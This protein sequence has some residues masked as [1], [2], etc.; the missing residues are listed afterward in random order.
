M[1][2]SPNSVVALTYELHTTNEEGQQVFVEKADEQNPLVFL[3][4]VGM[5][6]PKFE[7]HLTGLKTGDEYAF[8]LS[9]ADGYG[10]I[11]PGAFADLPKTMFTEAGGELPNVGDVI[12]LQDNNGNQFRAGVTAVHDETISVDLNHPMAGKNLVFNGVIL[13]VREATQDELAHG[14][15][16]GADGHSGH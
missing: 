7:E 9:A 5:M 14:H 8:E 10:D 12:P 2:I 4:G 1:N 6:L 15:A 3:Y 13:N 11:D 16:H